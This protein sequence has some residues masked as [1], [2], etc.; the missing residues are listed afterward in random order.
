MPRGAERR[1]RDADGGGDDGS[2]GTR[3]LGLTFTDA[4]RTGGRTGDRC[5]ATEGSGAVARR[6]H[7]GGGRGRGGIRSFV[8]GYDKHNKRD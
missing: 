7:V 4:V 8:M 2:R 1:W 5:E 3:G 6:R